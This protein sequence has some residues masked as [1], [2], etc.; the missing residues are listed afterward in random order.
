[1]ALLISNRGNLNGINNQRENSPDYVKEALDKGYY[2][3]VDV[4]AIGKHLAI[5]T[6]Y[7]QHVVSI[8]FLQNPRI[9]ARTNNVS[10]LTSLLE[11]KV[12][13]F[14]NIQDSLTNGGLLW[15]GYPTLEVTPRC[16]VYMPEW[17]LGD[18]NKVHDVICTGICSNFIE[19][20]AKTSPFW[21]EKKPSSIAEQVTEIVNDAC[22]I[23]A[24]TIGIAKDVREIISNPP[25]LEKAV[26]AVNK[27]K[28][29]FDD[30]VEIVDDTEK[31]VKSLRNK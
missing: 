1:M 17:M 11:S 3:V 15:R 20:V 29:I 24:D 30:A 26:D 14:L 2:V 10:T 18:I 9:F 7:A 22:E 28:E 25:S 4:W 6:H 16:I 21:T 8:D 13:C 31:I 5:G 27:S 23:G 12:H 19:K